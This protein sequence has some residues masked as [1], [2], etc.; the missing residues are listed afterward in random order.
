MALLLLE[1]QPDDCTLSSNTNDTKSPADCL[2]TLE[3]V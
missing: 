1:F 3:T 2:E